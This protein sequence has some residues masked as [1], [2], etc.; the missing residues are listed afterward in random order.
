MLYVI[1]VIMA[2]VGRKIW[3]LSAQV[4]FVDVCVGAHVMLAALLV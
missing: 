4:K 2:C 1:C 3:C